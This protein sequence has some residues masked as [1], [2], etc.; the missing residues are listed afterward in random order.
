MKHTLIN[1]I[2][3]RLL[4]SGFFLSALLMVFS[5]SYAII[6]IQI[7]K[8]LILVLVAHTVGG[9]AAG[10]GLCILNGFGAFPTILYNLYIEV[11][12]VCFTYAGFVLSTTNYLRNEWLIKL[13]A[14]L[15]GKALEQ[16][17]KIKPFGWIGIFL[18]VMAPL[19]VTGPVVGSIIGYMLRLS[20]FRNFSATFLGTLTAIIIWFYCFDFLEQ[21][22]HMIQYLFAAI[23]IIVL[24]PYLKK[25]KKFIADN[26]DKR[27]K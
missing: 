27:N 25:I 16:K 26:K 23:V 19:P 14:R 1:T 7:A 18:F 17:D 6:E 5:I 13:M 10:I 2:E 3:G 11:L 24:I 20:L 22:F 15:T 4:L 9:R 8:I 12:I 21:R